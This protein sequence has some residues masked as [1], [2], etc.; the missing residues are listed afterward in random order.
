[1]VQIS[2]AAARVNSNLNQE[3][4][5]K[6]LGITAK[7]LRGYEQGRV[8]IPS[9]KLRLAAKIYNIPSDM[10]R[11]NVIDDGEFDEKILNSTTV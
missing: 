9:D 8:V 2:L 6:K 7:T 4:A 3:E 5:S 1:M 11:L 10:I